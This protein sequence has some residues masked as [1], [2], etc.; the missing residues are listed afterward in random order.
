MNQD[1]IEDLL[2]RY[3]KK[4]TSTEENRL[5]EQWLEDNGNADPTWQ[6][7][8]RVEKDQW[9]SGVFA[10]IKGTIHTHESKVK[11]IRPL[12]HLWYKIGAA[13]A[14]LI[15]PLSLFLGWPQ[16]EKRIFPSEFTTIAVPNH[17]KKQ[18]IL[19][20]GSKVWLNA[21]ATIRFPKTFTGKLREIYLTGE[22]YFD[23]H[24]DDSKPFLIHNGKVLTTVLGTAFNIKEDQSRHTLEV[25]VTRGKVSVSDDG[26][27]LSILTPNQQ[28]KINLLNRKPTE[29]NVDAQTVIAWQDAEIVF[30]DITFE[31]AAI[32]LEQ[33]FNVKIAF[34]NDQLKNCRF[35]GSALKGDNLDKILE[36]ICA[37]NNA[38]WKTRAD[39]TI[40][41]D[42]SGCNN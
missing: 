5:I 24:H 6:K 16:F 34:R 21:G 40:M 2:D 11:V 15:I 35:S 37:F 18:I 36:V 32:Q 20:D 38:S 9:L 7:L 19:A 29:L 23:I 27:L 10:E 25:T 33:N 22:A 28:L 14:V 41:I 30:D 13:A 3:L 26:K 17:Q 39:G 31:D 4:E 8:D 12:K 42:G 1:N